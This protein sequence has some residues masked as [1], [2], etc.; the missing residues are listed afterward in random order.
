MV[1]KPRIRMI[2]PIWGSYYIDRWLDLCFASLRSEGNI[3][4]L[5]EH[6]DFELA[7]LTMAADAARM[8]ADAKFNTIMAGIR[9]RF[10]T[11][12]EF[13]PLTGKTTY[14]IPLTLAYAK[15]I[16]DLGES[17]I[18][19]YVILMNADLLLA[20]GSLKS[21]VERICDGYT[22][23]SA[24]S[25]RVIDGPPRA[26]LEEH[27]DKQTG[28]LTISPRAMMHLAISHLHSTVAGR[29]I[30]DLSPVDSVYYHQIYWRISDDCLAMRG[31]L[32]QP[33]CF[34]IERL[35]EKVICP[36]DY[37][38]ITEFCPNGRFCVLD[39]SDDY[40]MIELQERDSEC[41][42]LRVAPKEKKLER[43]L[44]RLALEII[45]NAATWATAEHRRNATKTI[46]YHASDLPADS[47]KRVAPFEAFV[48][49]ILAA[50]PTPVSHIS[51]FHWLPAVRIYKNDMIAGGSDPTIALLDDPRNIVTPTTPTSAGVVV[52]PNLVVTL[53]RRLVQL[54]RAV[55]SLRRLV[56][57]SRTV[58][59]L[60]RLV[61]FAW[62]VLML[63]LRKNLGK[64][65][66][67]QLM[68]QPGDIEVAYLG[69]IEN[70]APP[71]R[72]ETQIFHLGNPAAPGDRHDF[73]VIIPDGHP[74]NP[75]GT[76]I[77][78]APVSYFALWDRLEEDVDIFLAARRHVILVFI[79]QRF[80]PLSITGHAYILSVI[81]S[82]LPWRKFETDLKIFVEK[83]SR[84]LA[85]VSKRSWWS[86]LMDRLRQIRCDAILAI[87]GEKSDGA[88]PTRFSALVVSVKRRA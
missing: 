39:D 83:D 71:P 47:A 87:L 5:N 2:T 18:G 56:K 21:L 57:Y 15:G 70:Y 12:D 81:L 54:A 10:V 19:T 3:P 51:H 78:Y 11:I 29:I 48:D 14:G 34:R 74:G 28:I 67:L 64:F 46:Y 85:E 80:M 82:N 63:P 88:P 75:S 66:E 69:N 59:L 33:L 36:V 35:M 79:R 1:T 8:Q 86:R 6:C 7:I 53:L 32:L 17:V 62:T 16:L 68:K 52:R 65:V 13:F 25:I 38:F 61:Q 44:T 43:R 58:P 30:N 24:T 42:L 9:I 49:G 23:I 77:L 76:I 20:S 41:H 31:F 84:A 55:P 22:I 27:I 60:R 50:M 37:G 4:Y 45:A 26:A 72:R 73:N 40:L